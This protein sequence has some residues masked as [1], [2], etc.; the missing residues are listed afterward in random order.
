MLEPRVQGEALA[1]AREAGGVGIGGQEPAQIAA[2][3]GTR[4]WGSAWVG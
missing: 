2:E 3:K 4:Y 1:D